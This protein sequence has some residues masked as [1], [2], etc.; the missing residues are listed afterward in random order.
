MSMWTLSG[1]TVSSFGRRFKSDEDGSILIFSIFL[2]VITILVGGIAVD[3][4]HYESR[5]I[6]VQNTLDSAILGASSL[7]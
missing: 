5:R 3:V 1:G 6:A 2:F 4:M 7:D